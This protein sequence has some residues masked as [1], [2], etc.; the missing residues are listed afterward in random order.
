MTSA[1]LL[2]LG[3]SP[4]NMK[5]TVSK[6]GCTSWGSRTPHLGWR[7]TPCTRSA[8]APSC[9]REWRLLTAPSGR[10]LFGGL[11]PAEGSRLP[12]A[13]NAWKVALPPGQS[14]DKLTWAQTAA[15]SLR[16]PAMGSDRCSGAAPGVLRA[17]AEATR[18]RAPPLPPLHPCVSP[19]GHPRRAAC[20]HARTSLCFW[21]APPALDPCRG[22]L[23]PRLPRVGPGR[24]A[25]GLTRHRSPAW[26]RVLLSPALCVS[27]PR[28]SRTWVWLTEGYGP[29]REKAHV[30]PG[31]PRSV[32]R[33][34]IALQPQSFFFVFLFLYR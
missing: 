4:R 33:R 2:G 21:G 11:S 26:L 29:P 17:Q 19:R 8:H 31:Q 5:K 16:G 34:Q 32:G 7:Q 24:Q 14:A 12:L 9:S 3:G 27:F 30:S 10:S 23:G 25:P 22:L 28:P 13:G 20:P 15:R 1:G 6:A 18:L